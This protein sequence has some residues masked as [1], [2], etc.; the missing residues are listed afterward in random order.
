MNRVITENQI[1]ADHWRHHHEVRRTTGGGS[2]IVEEIAYS[3]GIALLNGPIYQSL[4]WVLSGH[5]KVYREV[6]GED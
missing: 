5:G 6:F 3:S 4:K 1:T 2:V